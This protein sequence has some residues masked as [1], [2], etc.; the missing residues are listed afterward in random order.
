MSDLLDELAAALTAA[1]ESGVRVRR[2]RLEQF[3]EFGHDA[4][5][6]GVALTALMDQTLSVPWRLWPSLPPVAD[7]DSEGVTRA[8][9]AVLRAV[10]DITVALVEGHQQARQDLVLGLEAARRDLVDDLLLGSP[11]VAGLLD[12]GARFG[13]A[14][15]GPHAVVVVEAEQPFVDDS[16]GTRLVTRAALDTADSGVLVATRDDRLVVI[17]GAAGRESLHDLVDRLTAAL[18]APSG[19]VRLART[20]PV[21]TWRMGVGRPHPGPPGVRT[22]Y[23][24]ALEALD[25]GRRIAHPSPVLDAADLLVHRVL[26]RDEAAMQDLVTTVLGPLLTARGGPEQYLSTLEAF[27]AEGGNTAATARRLHLSVRAVAYRLERIADLL[28]LDPQQPLDRF[29]LQTAVTGA[30]LLGRP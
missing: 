15:S 5:R 23:L 9:G 18:P 1:A 29:T 26:I 2:R 30:R 13:L 4:A 7:G 12:R 17:A 24:E 21:G 27:F 20:A 6:R 28:G 14:L 8:G 3:R 22:S 25:L 19:P 16:P 11:A 10:H